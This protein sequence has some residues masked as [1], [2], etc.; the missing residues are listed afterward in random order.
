MLYLKFCASHKFFY[1]FIELGSEDIKETGTQS[2]NRAFPTEMNKERQHYRLESL[3]PV[4]SSTLPKCV[5]LGKL[6]NDSLTQVFIFKVGVIITTIQNVI[7]ITNYLNRVG[8]QINFCEYGVCTLHFE[9]TIGVLGKTL[10]GKNIEWDP[11]VICEVG[12]D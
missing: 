12:E 3:D 7:R 8:L 10:W 1:L 5:I 9:N 4:P 6:F 2:N 11:E